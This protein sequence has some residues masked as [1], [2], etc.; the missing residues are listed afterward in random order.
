MRQEKEE[1]Q[2]EEEEE[3]LSWGFAFVRIWRLPM[4]HFRL[5]LPVFPK[6]GKMITKNSPS[7]SGSRHRFLSRACQDQMAKDTDTASLPKNQE[8]SRRSMYL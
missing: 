7:F 3:L 1:E 2:E 8:T 4:S 5:A 6:L